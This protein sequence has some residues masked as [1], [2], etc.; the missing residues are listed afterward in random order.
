MDGRRWCQTIAPGAYP[1]TPPRSRSR[2]QT[3]T[4]SPAARNTGSDPNVP[5]GAEPLVLRRDDAHA[6]FRG[7][8][9]SRIGGP[10]VDDDHLE[11][12]IVEVLQ[13]GQRVP[14][15]RRTVEG[16]D[17]HGNLRPPEVRRERGFGERT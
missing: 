4:S 3:S 8:L 10:V 15:R 16:G 6:I 9:R 12:R 7:D 17:D 13:A 2:Q 1:I 14:D 11:V 5:G